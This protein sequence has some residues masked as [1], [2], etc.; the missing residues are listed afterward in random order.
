MAFNL[1]S[2]VL[3]TPEQIRQEELDALNK[4]GAASAQSMLMG[5]SR[6]SPVAGSINALAANAIQDMPA[7]MSN[8]ARGGMMGLGSLVGAVNPQVG[9]EIQQGARSPNERKAMAL[10]EMISK[11]GTDAAGLRTT[12]RQLIQMGMPAEAAKLLELAKTMDVKEASQGNAE[13]NITF[14][15]EKVLKCDPKDKACM[16]KAMQMAV[17]YK[18][19]DTAA[20]Q[21][22]VKGYEKLNKDYESAE[23]SRDNVLT[24]NKSLKLLEEG[25]VNLGSFAKT[26]QGAQKF[27]TD[28]LNAVGIP[29]TDEREAVARTEELLA[30]TK[31]LAGQLLASGMFGSGTGISER[32]LQ[33]AMEMAGAGE[34]LTPEGMKRILELNAK[35]ERAK[36]MQY[37]EKLNRYSTA[38][39]ARSPEGSKEA[40]T[41]DIP[42]IYEMKQMQGTPF[43]LPQGATLGTDNRN[44][45]Q[46]YIYQGKAYTM[47]GKPYTYEENK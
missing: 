6:Y 34:N 37:N 18:R 5:S 43:R 25:K 24:A 12:A 4:R 26:R 29:V 21:M 1:L 8:V 19:G 30:N 45:K 40:F 39:W 20:N 15:A 3:K 44:G 22:T 27:Y 46:I 33:T 41:V 2:D 47:D 42:D 7:S 31:R 13:K 14:F 10:K 23:T 17:D 32:D 35:I 11:G 9:Q 38:F 36:L 28:L 16:E